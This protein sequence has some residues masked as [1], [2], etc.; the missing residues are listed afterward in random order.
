MI[1]RDLGQY[2]LTKYYCYEFY[3]IAPIN[4][5]INENLHNF[6]LKKKLP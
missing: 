3:R 6:V 1:C 4:I 2:F 5:K